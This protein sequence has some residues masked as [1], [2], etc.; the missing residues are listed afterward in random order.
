M[1]RN[2]SKC[3]PAVLV[4]KGESASNDCGDFHAQWLHELDSQ[5]RAGARLQT[6]G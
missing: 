3:F 5:Q 1:E 4:G 2:P 6:Y